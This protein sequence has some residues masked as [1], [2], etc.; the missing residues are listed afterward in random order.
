MYVCMYI[1]MYII[2][3]RRAPHHDLARHTEG[4]HPGVWILRT[5]EIR[6]VQAGALPRGRLGVGRIWC[7]PKGRI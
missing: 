1:Y 7:P 5:G 4:T 6:Q 3:P 2:D